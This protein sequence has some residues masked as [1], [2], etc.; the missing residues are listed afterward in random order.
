MRRNM[1]D[2]LMKRGLGD[3]YACVCARMHNTHTHRHTLQVKAET[4]ADVISTSRTP[5][6][7]N[8]WIW[9]QGLK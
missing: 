9:G 6:V 1:T 7:G 5:Q 3:R 8:Y 4:R 2:V